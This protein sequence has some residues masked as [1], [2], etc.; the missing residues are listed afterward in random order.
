MG[1]ITATSRNNFYFSSRIG[2]SRRGTDVGCLSSQLYLLLAF[3][4]AVVIKL[5]K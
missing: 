1:G 2:D 3:V 4:S 5:S